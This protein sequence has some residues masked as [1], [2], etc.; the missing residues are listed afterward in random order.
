MTEEQALFGDVAGEAVAEGTLVEGDELGVAVVDR[1]HEAIPARTRR[2][3]LE[4]HV[5]VER[6]AVSGHTSPEMA[7]AQIDDPVG[8]AEQEGVAVP[9]VTGIGDR[10]FRACLEK[11]GLEAVPVLAADG[12]AR[13]LAA[14]GE[15]G[16]AEGVLVAL[17]R[18]LLGQE[19]N[20]L[21]VVVP[22]PVLGP[23]QPATA[24]MVEADPIAVQR[25]EEFAVRGVG[26][27]TDVVA[28][29]RLVK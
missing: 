27:T 13:L 26:A 28:R 11:H 3:R 24:T 29:V 22:P 23:P 9:A 15:V 6:D 7:G 21:G 19:A 12:E 20:L 18:G 4:G 10:R 1:G 2:I 8:D 14:L 5:R 25:G 17:A 16:D